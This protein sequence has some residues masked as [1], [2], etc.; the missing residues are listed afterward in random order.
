MLM[1]CNV[2]KV[3]FVTVKETHSKPTEYNSQLGQVLNM[4]RAEYKA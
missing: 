4:K 3:F 1:Y 2:L